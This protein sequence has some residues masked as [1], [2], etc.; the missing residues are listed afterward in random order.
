MVEKF[1]CARDRHVLLAYPRATRRKRAKR[2]GSIYVAV[3]GVAV[4]VAICAMAGMHLAR[5]DLKNAVHNNNLQEAQLLA[6]S[7]VELAVSSMNCS[8]TDNNQWRTKF[9]NNVEPTPVSIGNGAMSFKLVDDDGD[10]ANDSIDSVWIYGY[11]R[12][13]EAV[14]V[15]R[16]SAR[17]NRGKPLESLRSALHCSRDLQI[18]WGQTLTVSGA[19]ASTDSNLLLNG[20]IVGDVQATSM[21]GV[22]SVSG[23]VE[24]PATRKGVPWPSVFNDYVARATPIPYTNSLIHV[25]LA[26]GVN[27][28]GGGVN[29]R[30]IY[31]LNTSNNN[32]T[33][34]Q[35]RLC[36]T[37]VIDAGTGTVTVN[38]INLLE[39]AREEFPVLI[40]K[41]N[42]VLQPQNDA[43][44]PNL[45]EAAYYHNFN[46]SGAPYLGA[47]D[48]DMT[49]NYPNEIRG[50]I[51]VTG[52]VT[53]SNSGIFH[54][55]I[56]VQGTVTVNGG[57]PQII[58]DPKLIANPPLG[59]SSNPAST[60]MILQSQSLS[61]QA[62]P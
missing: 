54:G 59:Y 46:P 53:I 1:P 62:S 31:Y 41:G 23:N 47:A 28:C 26:P 52:N 49:D 2:Q 6:N 37:L 58:W 25:V 50:L 39:P 27:E 16:A 35:M 17:N 56:L 9:T 51:H 43:S 33:I 30:G 55:A 3:L 15:E 34:Q 4:I 22:G 61:R 38:N 11:G 29:T 20:T 12:V 44:Y 60:N 10:L 18:G 19:P 32:V 36:G 13:G 42:T 40:I 45:S 57:S 48:N 5:I 8:P 21:S 7:S 24:V 14:W